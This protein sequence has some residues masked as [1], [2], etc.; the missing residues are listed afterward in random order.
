MI[1][2]LRRH[3]S[4]F[5]TVRRERYLAGLAERKIIRQDCVEPMRALY[6]E[7]ARAPVRG[8][9]DYA[10]DD[11]GSGWHWNRAHYVSMAN[12]EGRVCRMVG[13]VNNIED[14]SGSGQEPDR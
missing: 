11:K 6:A 2:K 5:T 9:F 10:A 13:V 12:E 7:A 3:D 4:G 8:I 14:K 1:Y